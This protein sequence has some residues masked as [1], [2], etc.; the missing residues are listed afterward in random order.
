MTREHSSSAH[1]LSRRD[2]VAQQT[3]V[4]WANLL[5]FLAVANLVP[6]TAVAEMSAAVSSDRLAITGLSPGA[7]I[8][9]LRVAQDTGP[10]LTHVVTR[11]EL[12]A[13][14]DK[15]ATI[16]DEPPGI[17][18]RSMWIMVDVAT[19]RA[20]HR[21]APG[22][23][24]GPDERDRRASQCSESHR[25]SPRHRQRSKLNETTFQLR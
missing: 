25:E 11:R 22:A 1:T 9:L 6:A 23:P 8:A 15:D 21:L 16:D 13:N 3:L 12:L 20:R 4:Q 2:R 17:A 5:A 14:D 19:G 10:Y 24:A 18:F 7:S